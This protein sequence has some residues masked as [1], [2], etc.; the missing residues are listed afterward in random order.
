MNR[1]G[2]PHHDTPSLSS[3]EQEVLLAC[4]EI[5]VRQHEFLPL[6]ADALG[7]PPEEV[8]YTWAFRRCQQR[9]NLKGTDWG[10]FFH[11]LEC[12]LRNPS[13]GRF[14]RIDFGPG[15]TV[16]SFT[17]WGVVQFVMTSAPPWAVFPSLR[18]MLAQQGPPFDEFSGDVTRLHEIWDALMSKGMLEPAAEELLAF[19]DAHWTLGPEGIP[20]ITFPEGTPERRRV[21]C[22]VAG[23]LRLSTRAMDVLAH[24]PGVAANGTSSR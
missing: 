17:A 8:F 22:M 1:A 20:V 7:V 19:Q 6:L 24:H 16:D 2:A 3:K 15:G 12:D 23:R 11:G 9:G 13:D 18:E 14:L 10:Y 5:V 21:D 4:R